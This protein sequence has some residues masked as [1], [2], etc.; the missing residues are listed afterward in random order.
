MM[1]NLK[2]LRNV[3]PE[4]CDIAEC[5]WKECFSWLYLAY[6]T[7]CRK[8]SATFTVSDPTDNLAILPGACFIKM[9]FIFPQEMVLSWFWGPDTPVLSHGC[10][11]FV[12][13]SE[14]KIKLQYLRPRY[15]CL[16]HKVYTWQVKRD[17]FIYPGR[18]IIYSF[19]V[20]RVKKKS[21]ESHMVET[22]WL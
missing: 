4:E 9:F 12:W 21:L 16:K 2:N 8:F 10:R 3:S 14:K 5:G 22:E 15:L 17:V 18:G 11:K 19:S 1:K 20:S 6:E 7:R 13:K